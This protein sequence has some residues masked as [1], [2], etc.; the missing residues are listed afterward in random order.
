MFIDN[1]KTSVD[2]QRR[3]L[4]SLALLAFLALGSACEL[5][6]ASKKRAEESQRARMGTPQGEAAPRAAMPM[7]PAETAERT[8]ARGSSG[9][10]FLDGRRAKL[11]DYRGQVVVLD[12]YATYC[13]PCREEIPHLVELQRRYGPQGFKIIGLNVGGAEDRVKV[14][15]YVRELGIQYQLA[16]PD[17]ATV[18]AFLAGNSS[19]P[20]TFVFDRQGK[21]VEHLVGYDQEV[22]RR[23]EKAVETAL[24]SAKSA[25]PEKASD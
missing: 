23:L 22:A 11:E 4:A 20:Q 16:D 18:N 24:A 6:G 17:D 14:P 9:W 5:D 25:E 7:P 8:N 10:T 12:F 13:P 1:F 19:I 15:D 3:A 21:L 2:F